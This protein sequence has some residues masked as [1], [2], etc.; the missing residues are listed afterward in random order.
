MKDHQWN[1]P[2]GSQWYESE[3]TQNWLPLND[4]SPGTPKRK[5]V[6]PLSVVVT[7]L[8]CAIVIFFA[9]WLE[10]GG[11]RITHYLVDDSSL[12]ALN[13]QNLRDEHCQSSSRKY[14]PRDK[15]IKIDFS[16]QP[17]VIYQK[18]IKNELSPNYCE[19]PAPR[20]GSSPGTSLLYVLEYVHTLVESS[21]LAGDTN[22]VVITLTL[23]AVEPGPGVPEMDEYGY[24]RVS[25]ILQS[26]KQ[27]NAVVAIVGPLGELQRKLE[28]AVQGQTNVE[29]CTPIDLRRCVDWAFQGGREMSSFEADFPG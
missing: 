3:Q 10:V 22:P 11:S 8:A 26:L 17:E 1:Q 16:D 4:S 21:R 13:D 25:E 23:H 15:S 6:L 14:K 29:I 24:R 27:K 2:S 19:L 20:S 7:A 28:V 9:A 5:S 18:D 12:S